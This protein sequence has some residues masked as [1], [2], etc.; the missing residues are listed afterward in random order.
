[1]NHESNNTQNGFEFKKRVPV[2]TIPEVAASFVLITYARP[3][4]T[5]LGGG[6]PWQGGAKGFAAPLSTTFILRG[7][8]SNQ[9]FRAFTLHALINSYSAFRGGVICFAT[10]RTGCCQAYRMA[11]GGNMSRFLL[12]LV[13][14]LTRS[15]SFKPLS[16]LV[17]WVQC[18]QLCLHSF[19]FS[20]SLI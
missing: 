15:S 4:A 19:H 20:Y 2:T 5:G 6:A 7:A 12:V 18:S 9:V 11:L 3:T 1:M 10:L 16:L 8:C 17:D 13:H 14:T